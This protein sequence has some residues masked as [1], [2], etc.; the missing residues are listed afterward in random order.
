M[1]PRLFAV[2]LFSRWRERR[3]VFPGVLTLTQRSKGRE[4]G[5]LAKGVLKVAAFL[6]PARTT[7]ASLPW[8]G[9]GAPAS[10]G[11]GGSPGTSRRR[12]GDPGCGLGLVGASGGRGVV[13]S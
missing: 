8:R 9:P 5:L 3:R 12:R 2:V 13:G 6:C 4:R 11:E 10:A 1:G 7:D